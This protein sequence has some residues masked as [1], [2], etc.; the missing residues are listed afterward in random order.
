MKRDLVGDEIVGRKRGGSVMHGG[1]EEKR[2]S[3]SVSDE[4]TGKSMKR[5]VSASGMQRQSSS[6]STPMSPSRSGLV[7]QSDKRRRVQWTPELHERFVQ[8]VAQV[9]LQ[10]AVPKI[11]MQLMDVEHLTRENVASHL[12]KYRE[13]I[14]K[15]KILEELK[16]KQEGDEG[17]AGGSGSVRGDEK[18][19]GDDARDEGRT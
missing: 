13:G 14:R 11:I 2:R 17:Q 16:K 10:N 8:A 6:S 19:D 4:D 7:L 5:A 15:K 12:Q 18:K 9:G 1:S 3:M